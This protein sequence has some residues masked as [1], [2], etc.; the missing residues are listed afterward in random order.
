MV[1]LKSSA[2]KPSKTS[3]QGGE[4]SAKK[5]FAAALRLLTRRDRSET[6]LRQKLKQLGFSFSNIE[7]AVDQCREYNYL[8]D[9]RFATE[10]AR[11]LMRTGRGVGSKIKL[12]LRNRGVNEDIAYVA[13]ETAESEFSPAQ[14][15]RD[16]LNR[17]FSTFD[18]ATADNRE[19]RRVISFFQRRGF[20]LELIF[21][22][23]K[24]E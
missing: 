6:E 5:T 3:G 9:H 1:K 10:R 20:S 15:L 16:Q 17:R 13:I 4:D 14:L 18:Y 19:R 11:T 24:E 23:V 2:S 22:I 7:A 12:D 21:S 8:N